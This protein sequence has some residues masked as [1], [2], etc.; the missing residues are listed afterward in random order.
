MSDWTSTVDFR[1]IQQQIAARAERAAGLVVEHVL[2]GAVEIVPIEEGTLG[3]SGQISTET[4][5]QTGVGAVS[6]N[7]SYAV[8]QH[9]EL[10]YH[11]DQGRSAK[12]LEQPL[13]NAVGD[14]TAADI[15]ATE[16]RKAFQ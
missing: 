8:R 12:Y 13:L 11:H 2:G 4:Q 16:M 14:G 7:T 1:S 9:E 15:A 5:G 10:D 3:R 6:F